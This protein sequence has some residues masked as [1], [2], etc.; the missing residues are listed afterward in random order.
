MHAPLERR[1]DDGPGLGRLDAAVV[2]AVGEDDE[3]AGEAVAADV[4]GLPDPAVVDLL[5]DGVVE[6]P[7][8]LGAA[9]V[10]LAV[11]ADEEERMVDRLAGRREVEP[12]QIV[13]PLELEAA[14]LA[15]AL[16][17]AGDVGDEPVRAAPARRGGR[18]GSAS[19]ADARA[20]RRGTSFSSR[21]SVEPSTAS[22]A[23]RPRYSIRIQVSTRLAVAC[24]DSSCARLVS[25][26]SGFAVETQASL[27]GRERTSRQSHLPARSERLGQPGATGRPLARRHRSPRPGARRSRSP[28]SSPRRRRSRVPAS[29]SSPSATSTFS[30]VP[31]IGLTTESL[32]AP[33]RPDAS[34]SRRRRASSTQGGSGSSTVTS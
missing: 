14:K 23:Q 7:A 30:T 19:A 2:D 32:P 21:P 5:A 31:C 18:R 34:R 27:V 25:A 12:D 8:E 16:G 33:P 26:Q 11:R 1:L 28:S 17:R 4:R 24:S 9:A 10:V 13:V 6:R 15:L 3:V 20:R 22:C 29:T